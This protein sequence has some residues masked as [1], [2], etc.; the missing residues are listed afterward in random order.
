MDMPASP[1]VHALCDKHAT[2][3][4]QIAALEKQVAQH[5]ADLMHVDAVLRLFAHRGPW[6]VDPLGGVEGRPLF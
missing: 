4:G 2:L 1:V 6:C 3:S 5:R